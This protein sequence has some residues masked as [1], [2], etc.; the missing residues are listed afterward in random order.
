MPV[1]WTFVDVKRHAIGVILIVA[2]FAAVLALDP[3]KWT[4]NASPIRSVD[5]IDAAVKGAH[6]GK[7]RSVYMLVLE[8]GSSVFI[9]DDRPRLIG[10]H[11]GIERVTRD[12][13]FVF[14]RF[15]N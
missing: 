11:V 7:G 6:W 4:N 12:N 5:P 15:P 2:L 10:S 9:D 1:P 3:L 14:Y 8:D 13:G